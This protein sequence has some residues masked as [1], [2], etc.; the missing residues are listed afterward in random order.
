MNKGKLKNLIIGDY[1]AQFG[2]GLVLGGGFGVG[3][4]AEP[5]TTIRRSNIGFLPY[6]SLNELGFFRGISSTFQPTKTVSI[7]GFF[8]SLAKDGNTIED[9]TGIALSSLTSSGLHRSESEIMNR[10]TLKETNYGLVFTYKLKSLEAGVIMHHTM[11]SIPVSPTRRPYNQFAFR[12][13]R[14]HQC[15]HIS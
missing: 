12:G 7:S 14:K 5:I 4:S 2:Q 3:K 9:S 1:Q 11:L 10:K 6:T 8:S 15:E 13:N